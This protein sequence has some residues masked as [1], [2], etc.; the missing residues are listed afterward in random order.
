MTEHVDATSLGCV[1]ACRLV[2]LQ[3]SHRLRQQLGELTLLWLLVWSHLRLHHW[4]SSRRSERGTEDEDS[5]RDDRLGS[6]VV[7]VDLSF[8]GGVDV[9]NSEVA[10]EHV[11]VVGLVADDRAVRKG[12]HVALG[13]HLFETVDVSSELQKSWL[14]LKRN[15]F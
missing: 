12:P 14:W 8:C 9:S 6:I 11:L 4:F 10:T 5:V 15:L 2:A 13:G 3:H 7:K 1:Q